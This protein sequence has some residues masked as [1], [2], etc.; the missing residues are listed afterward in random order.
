V[1]D[2]REQF[3]LPSLAFLFVQIGPSSSNALTDGYGYR[4]DSYGV[5]QPPHPTTGLS[6]SLQERLPT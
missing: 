3:Q 5:S 4:N 2:W 6:T 1:R